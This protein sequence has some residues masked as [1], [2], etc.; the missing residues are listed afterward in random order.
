[1]LLVEVRDNLVNFLALRREADADRTAIDAA[2]LMRK[3]AKFHQLLHIVGDVG[4][5]IVAPRAQFAGCHVVVADIV[6]EQR[7]HAVHIIATAAIEFVLDHI[8][9]T[10]VKTLHE[11]QSFKVFRTNDLRGFC[12]AF[13]PDS[14]I[15][16]R[17][18]QHPC[19][20]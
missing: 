6:E 3:I 4:A 20:T 18:V 8:Q 1:M 10:A 5:E 15:A 19:L 11:G 12:Y 2:A 17:H 14:N 7:L 13:R 16:L 9:K